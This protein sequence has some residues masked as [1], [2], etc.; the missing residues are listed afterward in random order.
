MNIPPNRFETPPARPA[1]TRSV[2]VSGYPNVWTLRLGA[3]LRERDLQRPL[4]DVAA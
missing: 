4:N 2:A 3:G 1:L